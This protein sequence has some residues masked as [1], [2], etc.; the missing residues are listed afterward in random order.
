MTRL[1]FVVGESWGER[2]CDGAQ[3]GRKDQ[4]LEGN[5]VA[6]RVL[7]TVVHRKAPAIVEMPGFCDWLL[8]NN[9]GLD[10]A[11]FPGGACKQKNDKPPVI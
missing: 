11:L 9:R 10:P 2:S 8:P 3:L 1:V 6:V 4:P 5:Q 7:V